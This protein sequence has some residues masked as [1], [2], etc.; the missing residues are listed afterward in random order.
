MISEDVINQRESHRNDSEILF[1]RQLQLIQKNYVSGV[2]VYTLIALFSAFIVYQSTQDMR[3]VYWITVMCFESVI[4]VAL[5]IYAYRNHFGKST[6]FDTRFVLVLVFI[7]SITYVYLP[8]NFIPGGE[9][10][11]VVLLTVITASMAAGSAAL[12][13]PFFPG[14]VVS[15][16]PGMLVVSYSLISREEPIY[17]WLGIAFAFILVGLTWFTITITK[18]IKRSVEISMENQGLIKSLRRAL[19]ETDEANQAKSVFLASASHDLRQ[20]LH[21]LGLLNE[22]LGRTQLDSHQRELHHHMHSALS[23][24][25]DMLDALLNISKL[26]AGAISANPK[27]FLLGPVFRKLES[28]LAPTADEKGLVFRTR[29]TIAAANSDPFIVEL[30]L[31]NLISNAIRYTIEGGI[32][33]ACR[34]RDPNL[35]IEVWDTGIG[36]EPDARENIFKAFNQIHNPERD[37]RKGFGL[38][39]A[40]AQGLADTIGTRISVDSKEG[41]GTV[42]RFDISQADD[43]IIVDEHESFVETRFDS[44]TVMIVDDDPSILSSMEAVLQGWG[45][46]TIVGETVWEALNH[47]D[48]KNTRLL[49]TDYRLRDQVTGKEVAKTVRDKLGADLPVI[50]ITGD[51]AAE[52]IRDAQST[53]ALLL[54]KPASTSQLNSLMARLLMATN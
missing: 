7:Q 52:R 22:S 54:H 38:G 42:F 37:S 5:F 6:R 40:I 3:V 24:T 25:R 45:C 4:C 28:E 14:F 17:Q 30:I 47:P 50:I 10:G 49:L 26:E 36:I 27:P 13:S 41:R 53:G 11:I 2:F 29:E 21:A 32:L 51:T 33:V 35:S 39:L 34:R 48:A 46:S 18:T 8:F 23:S 20:P 9:P 31:R 19:D 43:A 1:W 16:Y 12:S 15:S 44:T